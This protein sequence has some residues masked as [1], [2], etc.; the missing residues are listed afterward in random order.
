MGFAAKNRK[1]QISFAR[2]TKDKADIK[3]TNILPQTPF[4]GRVKHEQ[5][6]FIP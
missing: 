1:E 2:N 5:Q 4:W 6:G 3:S